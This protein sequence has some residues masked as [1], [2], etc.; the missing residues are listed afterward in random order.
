MDYEVLNIRH[1]DK[2]VVKAGFNVR[3]YDF[4][5]RDWI[6]FSKNGEEW[7]S[8]PS[9]K[10]TDNDGETKYFSYVRI[11]DKTKYHKFMDWLLKEVTA[12]LEGAAKLP[13]IDRGSS[14]TNTS[15]AVTNPRISA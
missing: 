1:V 12:A 8:G 11:E 5:I 13:H 3:I 10:Y 6:L 7:I 9:R 2:G 4:T 14:A 15:L